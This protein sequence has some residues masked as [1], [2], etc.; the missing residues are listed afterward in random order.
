MVKMVIDL[1]VSA[2][3]QHSA[4]FLQDKDDPLSSSSKSSCFRLPSLSLLPLTP[5]IIIV[6]RMDRGLLERNYPNVY[7]I[8]GAFCYLKKLVIVRFYS[9]KQDK[10][11]FIMKF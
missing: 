5:L 4:I 10:F 1:K 9:L 7:K 11:V 3:I 8:D 6:R 2:I